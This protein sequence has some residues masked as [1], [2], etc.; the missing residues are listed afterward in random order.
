MPHTPGLHIPRAWRHAGEMSRI[1]YV[2]T[3]ANGEERRLYAD[4]TSALGKVLNDA[5]LEVGYREPKSASEH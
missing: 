5:L 4:E 3:M 1:H 2:I